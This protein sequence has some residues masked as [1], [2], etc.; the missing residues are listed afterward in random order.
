MRGSFFAQALCGAASVTALAVPGQVQE[1]AE[2]VDLSIFQPHPF[3]LTSPAAA[4]AMAGK[5][6]AAS[7][8]A[9]AHPLN[10]PHVN[11]ASSG[12]CTNP[13]VH[14]EWRDLTPVHRSEYIAASK[15][16]FGKPS[17]SGLAGARNRYEDLQAV[18]QHMT[19]TI[20]GVGQ[21][22]PWHRYFMHAHEYLLRTECGYTGPMTWWDETKDAGHFST[23]PMFTSAYFGSAPVKTSSGQGTCITN[24]AFANTE[25]YIG[26]GQTVNSE[27][28]LSRAVNEG[29]SKDITMSFV[30]SCNSHENFTDMWKCS[31]TGYV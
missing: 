19:K 18:H 20:H 30:N 24:G 21:F 15:C 14:Y 22:L 31:Y 13:A 5:D 1:T 7:T 11:A 25:L 23:A 6:N 10:S 16:L 3:P 28:C 4:A 29:L 27:H 9:T 12:S 2:L 26:P 8:P 17:K